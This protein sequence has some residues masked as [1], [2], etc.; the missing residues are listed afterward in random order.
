MLTLVTALSAGP[1]A[2]QA[3]VRPPLQPVIP[4]TSAP[5]AEGPLLP[6]KVEAPGCPAGSSPDPSGAF[7][8]DKSRAWICARRYGLDHTVLTIVFPEPMV[9]TGINLTP[10][11]DYVEPNGEDHWNQHRLVTNILWNIGGN[12][13]EQRI[14]P[15][16][17][18]AHLAVPDIAA[19]VI[20]ATIQDTQRP[21]AAP[22]DGGLPGIFGAAPNAKTVDKT[23]AIGR[24]EVI[25]RPA[26][27]PR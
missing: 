13:L 24:I 16:R 9:V 3:A 5:V 2:N 10:G 15:S 27:G 12:R 4:Q 23:F 6:S 18:G 26:G 11:F 7:D 21:P 17:A 14:A 19:T 8:P 1:A 20:T 25:G 22:P